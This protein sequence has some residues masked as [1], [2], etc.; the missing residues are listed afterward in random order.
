MECKRKN[1]MCSGNP[2]SAKSLS[3]GKGKQ[4]TG[5]GSS[6][7]PSQPVREVESE[8]ETVQRHGEHR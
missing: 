5:K 8:P 4:G 2:V 7:P 1:E 3:F 6:R